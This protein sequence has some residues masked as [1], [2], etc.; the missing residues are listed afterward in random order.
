[1]NR[2]IVVLSIAT[3]LVAGCAVSGVV[4]GTSGSRVDSVTPDIRYVSAGRTT[5]FNWARCPIA[6]LAF[7]QPSGSVEYQLD[8]TMVQLADQ[9]W[10]LPVTVAQLSLPADHGQ[11][12]AAFNLHKSGMMCLYDPDRI[13][14]EAYGRP[15]P[16]EVFLIDEYGHIV[17]AG[18]LTN[19]Q[20]VLDEARRL[21]QVEKDRRARSEQG[22]SY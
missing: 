4:T 13:A 22:C 10:D 19:P 1:M 11:D 18:S 14:W 5:S 16:G 9:L 7:T 15:T 17:M 6:L 20:P 12:R 8:P 3:S 2:L 21:G